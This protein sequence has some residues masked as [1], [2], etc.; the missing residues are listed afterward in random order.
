MALRTTLGLHKLPN[1]GYVFAGTCRTTARAK[2]AS[3]GVRLRGSYGLGYPGFTCEMPDDTPTLAESLRSGGYATF[4]VRKWHLTG[5]AQLHDATARSSWPLQR[6][7][8]RY[9]GSMDGFTSLHH[10]HRIVRDNSVIDMGEL[11]EG[12]FFTDQLIRQASGMITD[13][14]MNDPNKPFFLY[15]SHTAVRGPI[16]AKDVDIEQYR[17][18]YEPGWQALRAERFARQ[19]ELGVIPPHTELPLLCNCRWRQYP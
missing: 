6:G 13:L 16:Q 14:R 9:F 1:C 15:Y 8:D 3:S 7:F 18:R 4:H 12:Y 17:G 19:H 11:A 5:E 10:P 2:L